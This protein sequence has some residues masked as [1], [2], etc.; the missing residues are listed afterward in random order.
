MSDS[1]K[2]NQP[3][4]KFSLEEVVNMAKSL[5]GP[6]LAPYI[7]GNDIKDIYEDGK[8][9]EYPVKICKS[10]FIRAAKRLKSIEDMVNW[11]VVYL[12]SRDIV[13]AKNNYNP[14]QSNGHRAGI[15]KLDDKSLKE[16]VIWG[17][18][19]GDRGEDTVPD[20]WKKYAVKVNVGEYRGEPSYELSYVDDSEP[21]SKNDVI[22]MLLDKAVRPQD[23]EVVFEDGERTLEKL[24][25]PVV[26]RGRTFGYFGL[27]VWGTR[28]DENGEPITTVVRDENGEPVRDKTG[29]IVT[30][31]ERY[32]KDGE[33][34]PLIQPR[35]DDSEMGI[36]TFGASLL[37]LEDDTESKNRVKFRFLNK[38][39]G[40]QKVDYG[41][42]QERVFHDAIEYGEEPGRKAS[43]HL[44]SVYSGTEV[45]I[46]GAPIRHSYD[47]DNDLHYIDIE[48]SMLIALDLV[49]GADVPVSE[50]ITQPDAEPQP[51]PQ[52][53]PQPQME[54]E[55][56]PEPEPETR[57]EPKPVAEHDDMGDIERIKQGIRET[58]ELYGE[59][60][61][62]QDIETLELPVMKKFTGPDNKIMPEYRKQVAMV[63]K[64]MR[65]GGSAKPE[66][67][68]PEEVEQPEPV[69]NISEDDAIDQGLIKCQG[70]GEY[71][72]QGEILD[73]SMNCPATKD[74]M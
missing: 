42:Y 56:E 68:E 3:L 67:S 59:T 54:P 18:G 23:L 49:E 61:T 74:E 32:V 9:R 48:A 51:Q 2:L 60:A 13:T 7:R 34:Q 33:E 20:F 52:P 17:S 64:K 46:V 15:I 69:Q 22:R 36:Y 31:E 72:K 21:I 6:D 38:K 16:A 1:K 35:L 63:L 57:P 47:A 11:D 25:D 27:E 70:C 4:K 73:H 40:R 14:R 66:P 71:F 30:R 55:P 19:I 39:L 10:Y 50:D 45:L 29:K 43:D 58:Q 62:I 24:Y 8:K 26:L 5:V 41:P 44:N 28:K 65:E 37:P 53:E 12:G